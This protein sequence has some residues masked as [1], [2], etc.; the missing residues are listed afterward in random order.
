MIA[1]LEL[2]D[3]D[4]ANHADREI[5]LLEDHGLTS[6]FSARSV[7]TSLSRC[8]GDLA[9]EVLLLRTLGGGANDDFVA[10]LHPRSASEGAGARC[11]GAAWTRRRSPPCG[12]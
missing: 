12:M 3:E 8:I 9:N 5:G 6:D 7:T 11:P 1:P 4:V 2:L 10:D